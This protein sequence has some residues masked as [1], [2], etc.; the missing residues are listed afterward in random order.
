MALTSGARLGPYEIVAPLGA[1]GMGEVYRARDLK[2]DRLVA[3]KVLPPQ[4]ADS[5]AALGR[6]EREAK[7]VAAL[8]H[9]N[10]LAI[11]DFGREGDT[12]Y[13]V[14]ELL[15]G[16]TLRQKLSAPIPVRKAVEYA[17]QIARGLAAAHAKGIVH[18]DLKPENVFVTSDGR[19]KI[20]DFGLARQT[21]AFAGPDATMSPTLERHTDAGTVLGT[22]GYMSPEQARGEPGDHRSD[23]FSLGTLLY[24]LITGR[25]AFQRDTAAETLTA[26]LREDPPEL[27]ATSSLPPAIVRLVHHCLEKNP[28]ERFQSASDVAFA[29]ESLS[30]TSTGSGPAA[31]VASPSMPRSYGLGTILALLVAATAIAAVAAFLGGRSTAKRPRE[32]TFTPLTYR[33]QNILRALFAPDGKTVVFSSA[34]NGTDAVVFTLDPE[35]PEARPLLRSVHLLSISSKNELAILTHPTYLNHRL[36]EGTLARLPL[37]GGAPREIV[38]GVREADWSPDGTNLAIVRNIEGRDRL[39]FPIG[40]VLYEVSGY[41]SDPRVAPDGNRVAF[42]EHPLR[43]DDRGGVAVVDLAGRKTTLSDGYWG[44][45]GLA[46]SRDG[47]EV[48]FSGGLSYSQFKVFGATLSGTVRQALESAGGLTLYDVAPDGRW[49]AARDDIG[50]VMMVKAPGARQESDLSWLDLSS[51]QRF[52]QDGRMLLFTEESGV[53]GNN[54][55]ICLRGTD[56]SPVVRLGEGE[57][58]DLSPDGKWAV[59]IVPGARHVLMVYPTGA[60]E[61]RRLDPGPI[62]TYSS[63]SWFPDGQRLLACGAEDSRAQRCYVHDL[64]GGPPRVV[65]PENTGGALVAPDGRRFLA[66]R[67]SQGDRAAAGST[68]NAP[69]LFSLDGGDPRAVPGLTDKDRAIRWAPDGRSLYVRNGGLPARV[70]RVW[71]ET[72]RRELLHVITPAQMVGATAITSIRIGDDPDVYAY[73]LNQQL[74]RLFVVQGVR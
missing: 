36:F 31:L 64:K 33:Q 21:P 54:Y 8:S 3:V 16:E 73:A 4:L 51:P 52:S 44:L 28:V 35:F 39:E 27:T 24:E 63:A 22:V 46:W 70:E 30:S 10:I 25:R 42:F 29:L 47:G 50:T 6:F 40:K 9:P 12:A 37:G 13:A 66:Q 41:L 1:G 2:L 38:E 58:A 26:I 55:A 57:A 23:L 60:G 5:A 61:P 43:Y 19:V 32:V 68:A 15:D 59:A 71:L 20:L 48:L 34:L 49:L 14:M 7:A 45:E 65:T 53:V 69:E 18:R 11:F 72:G 17:V 67:N 74:S 62:V 56:G